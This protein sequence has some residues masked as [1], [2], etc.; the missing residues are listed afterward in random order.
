MRKT[1]IAT[2][3]IILLLCVSMFAVFTPKVAATGEAII[4]SLSIDDTQFSRCYDW[5][6][7]QNC[8]GYPSEDKYDVAYLTAELPAWD[9]NFYDGEMLQARLFK[10][11]EIDGVV[12]ANG[13]EIPIPAE[14]PY[15]TMWIP[16]SRQGGAIWV[17][18]QTFYYDQWNGNTLY[19]Q[20]DLTWS[21]LTYGYDQWPNYWSTQ[22]FT[23]SVN[24]HVWN[25]HTYRV[26]FAVEWEHVTPGYPMYYEKRGATDDIPDASNRHA[27]S[28]GTSHYDEGWESW[29]FLIPDD[30]IHFACSCQF[31]DVWGSAYI[32]N[33]YECQYRTPDYSYATFLAASSGATARA[34]YWIGGPCTGTVYIHGD[35]MQS[36]SRFLVYVSNDN[37]NWQLSREQ[38]V[39]NGGD[40]WIDCGT[41]SGT[42]QFVLI[43]AYDS[44]TTSQMKIDCVNCGGH[45]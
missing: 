30:E 39:Y 9:S 45:Y 12:V 28:V 21:G 32:T 17:D 38:L 34:S 4:G 35:S 18:D 20:Y 24:G 27:F 22:D 19:F 43:I 7:E 3:A 11:L 33:P 26:S 16:I 14:G 31:K 44:G 13:L 25:G 42:Y 8:Y 36:S 6:Y 5:S 40:R 1:R 10:V 41:P 29:K 37:Y 23:D 15:P 2:L